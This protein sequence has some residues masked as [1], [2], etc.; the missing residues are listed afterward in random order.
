MA[1]INTG[2]SAS[3]CNTQSQKQDTNPHK[4][5]PKIVKHYRMT[6][7]TALVSNVDGP[8][9]AVPVPSGL[10]IHSPALHALP[11]GA[12]EDTQDL[13]SSSE[14][15]SSDS[16]QP[17]PAFSQSVSLPAEPS[18]ILQGPNNLRAANPYVFA[19]IYMFFDPKYGPTFKA[20][21][22]YGFFSEIIFRKKLDR[23]K[24]EFTVFKTY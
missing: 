13:S 18:E 9:A 19:R 4:R 1:V 21:Q 23:Q 24:F 15:A 5:L 20:P 10:R 12:S 6:H 8:P 11:S 16:V 17:S 22:S 14:T 3:Q 7:C 2:V